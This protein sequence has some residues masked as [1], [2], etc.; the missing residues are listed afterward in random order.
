MGILWDLGYL[1]Q[2][3]SRSGI[4]HM[5]LESIVDVKCLPKRETSRLVAAGRLEGT[6]GHPCPG[7]YTYHSSLHPPQQSSAAPRRGPRAPGPALVSAALA[8]TVTG[9]ALSRGATACCRG[10]VSLA[11][12]TAAPAGRP[13]PGWG[14]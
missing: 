12:G 10:A 9:P 14:V 3:L 6:W 5:S 8:P 1:F 13:K 4:E 11:V 2:S 7:T